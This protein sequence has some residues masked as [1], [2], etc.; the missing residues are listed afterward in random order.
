MVSETTER[1]LLAQLQLLRPRPLLQIVNAQAEQRASLRHSEHICRE[2]KWAC[3]GML[4]QVLSP[5][6]LSTP[7]K[8]A[9]L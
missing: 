7:Q 3:L 4:A 8:M 5:Q 1:F 9:W 6:R 2:Q